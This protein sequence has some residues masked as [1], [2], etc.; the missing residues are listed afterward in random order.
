MSDID[1]DQ[2][3]EWDERYVYHVL[4]TREE[5]HSLPVAS[6]QGCYVTLADGRIERIAAILPAADAEV[7]RAEYRAK[8]AP[9]D[10]AR[11]DFERSVD[12][13]RDTFRA[14]P[15]DIEA[16]RAAMAEARGKRQKF[17]LLLHDII[18]SAANKMSPAGRQKLADWSP[19]GRNPGT[20]NR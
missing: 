8:A 4:A 16:T 1:W 11:E 12:A 7:I 3:R 6:A 13:I 10:A 14:A 17:D 9:V 2:V 5:Y 18:A 15:Y 20:T 19:T